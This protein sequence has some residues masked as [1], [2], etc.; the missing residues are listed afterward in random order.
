[1]VKQITHILNDPLT[2]FDAERRDLLEKFQ[3]GSRGWIHEAVRDW[4]ESEAASSADG[5]AQSGSTSRKPNSPFWLQAE[6]GMG[7]SAFVAFQAQHF[8][9]RDQL[10]AV[11]LCKFGN[12]ARTD[13]ASI[14]N[15][16]AVQIAERL[17]LSR[18]HMLKAAQ[19][20]SKMNGLGIHDLID[21]LLIDPLNQCKVPEKDQVILIDAVD[22]IGTMGSKERNEFLK[23]LVKSL[24]RFPSW[25]KVFLTSRPEED[26]KKQLNAFDPFVIDAE[27]PRHEKDLRQYIEAFAPSLLAETASSED[28]CDVVDLMMQKSEGRFVYV[29]TVMEQ[30]LKKERGWSLESLRGELPDGLDDSYKQNFE[31]I[32]ENIR[33]KL[34]E[35]K[36]ITLDV[37]K[38]FLSLLVTM[39]EPLSEKEAQRILQIKQK[40]SLDKLSEL[41]THMFPLRGEAGQKCYF[42]FHKSVVDFLTDPS[43]S[44]E[45]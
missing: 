21:K 5:G 8:E 28:C 40:A 17:P 44:D 34:A 29:A 2:I 16:L 4:V 37:Y 31:R 38:R 24:G 36:I 12:K 6:A 32:K 45:L 27:D 11:F 42:W 22:E 13:V 30:L 10:L 43:R 39:Q 18:D 19:D 1:M 14:V 3:P 20:T 35:E 41:V 26:I 9:E 25:V 7:K 33:V 15:S 23:F